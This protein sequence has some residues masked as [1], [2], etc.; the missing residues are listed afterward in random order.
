MIVV[1]SERFK[2]EFEAL[3]K[4]TQERA[5][6]QLALFLENP[7]H[8][9]LQV[10]KME[11]HAGLWEGRITRAYRFTFEMVGDAYNMRRIGPHDI[12][13]NT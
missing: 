6:K 7:R 4:P 12:L 13:K 5:R 11:G 2:K 8:P 1:K 3:P 10:K 9:S